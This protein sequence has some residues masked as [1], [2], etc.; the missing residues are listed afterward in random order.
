MT[1]PP[2]YT[3]PLRCLRLPA[4]LEARYTAYTATR[5]GVP[6]ATLIRELV[7]KGLDALGK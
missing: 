1:R 7:A 4:D 3:G 2:I 6:D 5:P